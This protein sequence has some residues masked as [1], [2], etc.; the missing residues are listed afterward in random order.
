MGGLARLRQHLRWLHGDRLPQSRGSLLKGRIAAALAGMKAPL[1]RRQDGPVQDR[2]KGLR[3][4]IYGSDRYGPASDPDVAEQA[5]D[6]RS[7]QKWQ[8]H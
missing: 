8:V 6:Q 4:A 7:R 1:Q 5:G 2:W 3:K